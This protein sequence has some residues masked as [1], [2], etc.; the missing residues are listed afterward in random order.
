[1]LIRV[2]GLGCATCTEAENIVR[3]A[4]A[5]VG[6]DATVEKVSDLRE[7]MRLGILSTPAIAMGNKL[8]CSGRVPSKDEVID[9][10]Y[11]TDDRLPGITSCCSSSTPPCC[12]CGSNKHL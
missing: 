3:A 8:V 9:W 4:V 1:M 6:S 2:F 5:E 11:E 12:S 7:M 10:I